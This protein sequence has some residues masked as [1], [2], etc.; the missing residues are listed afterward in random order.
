MSAKRP[1]PRGLMTISG[2]GARPL[3]CRKSHKKTKRPAGKPEGASRGVRARS[4][5]PIDFLATLVPLLRLDRQG[6]DRA[7]V[8]ALERDRFAGFL[9][10][11]VGA[12]VEARRARRRSWRSACAAGRGRAV[13]SRDRFPTT[14]DRRDRDGFHFRSA[15]WPASRGSRAECPLS[16]PAACAGNIRAADRT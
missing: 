11:A 15:E 5:V 13:R 1:T 7:G 12:V 6:R 16:R 2:V 14:R 10:I 9:A 8:E 3:K 4:V